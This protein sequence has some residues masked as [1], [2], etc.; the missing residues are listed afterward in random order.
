MSSTHDSPATRHLINVQR[1][2]SKHVHF[3]QN[4]DWK[5]CNE[6]ANQNTNF[7]AIH[8]RM[9]SKGEVYY[10]C[11]KETW[12]DAATYGNTCFGLLEYHVLHKDCD[13]LDGCEVGGTTYSQLFA[14]Y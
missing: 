9:E 8:S 13:G 5:R 7:L 11:Y 14:I 2:N 1:K 3:T 6:P 12:L 4:Q 10:Y